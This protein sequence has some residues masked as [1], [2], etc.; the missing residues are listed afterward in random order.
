MKTTT[1][2]L[3]MTSTMLVSGLLMFAGYVWYQSTGED[4][5]DQPASKGNV[6][7][8]SNLGGGLQLAAPNGLNGTIP[9]QTGSVQGT[10]DTQAGSSQLPTPDQFYLYE[11]YASSESALYADI[12]AGS[13]NT[14][15]PGDT[16]AVVYK[17]WLT[18]GEL[19]DQSPTN[20]QGQTE[21]FSFKLGAGQV[22]RGWEQG[23]VGMKVGGERRLV[24]PS[25]FG[26][27]KQGNQII[28]PDSML[29][30][31]VYV[32]Q[33]VDQANPESGL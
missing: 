7:T 15:K 32:Y 23:I 12:T 4:L 24:I 8:T 5:A 10:A 18:N 30:F 22:I 20:D 26:Y 28:P 11:E 2:L 6:A 17:G 33:I 3:T 19:F 29:I 9:L 16:V 14:V 1:L 25:E 31:D 13:G 27:G 21:A